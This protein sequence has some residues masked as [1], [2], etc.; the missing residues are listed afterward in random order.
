MLKSVWIFFF[1]AHFGIILSQHPRIL[2]PPQQR[3]NLL[4]VQYSNK[5]VITVTFHLLIYEVCLSANLADISLHSQKNSLKIWRPKQVL[6]FYMLTL[7]SSE[8]LLYFIF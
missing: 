3:I 7:D 5:L 4:C 6:Y 8:I 2:S 1:F